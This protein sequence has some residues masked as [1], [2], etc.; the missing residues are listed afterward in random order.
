MITMP[1]ALASSFRTHSKD[2]HLYILP[3]KAFA[4]GIMN[5]DRQ[6]PSLIA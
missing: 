2:I 4:T 1:I 3:V 5:L 6:K